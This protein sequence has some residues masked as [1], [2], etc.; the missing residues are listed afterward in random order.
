MASDHDT[1]LVSDENLLSDPERLAALHQTEL[2]DSLPEEAFDRIVR[3][4]RA[5]VGVP[6]SLVSLVDGSRQY[7][8]AQEGLSGDAC[9][10]RGTPLSHSFCQYVVMRDAPLVVRDARDDPVLRDNLAVPD[11]NVIAYLGVPIRAPGGQPIGSFCV[12]DGNPRDWSDA[13]VAAVSDLAATVESEISLRLAVAKRQLLNRELNHRVGNLF[14]VIG[15]MVSMTSRHAETPREMSEVLRGRIAALA[16]AHDLIRP[17]VM[18]TSSSVVPSA[19]STTLSSLIEPHVLRRDDQLHLEGPMLKLGP[20]ATTDLSLVVHELATNAAKYG[21]LSQAG[22]MLRITWQVEGGAVSLRWEEAGGPELANPP[23]AA[24]FGSQLIRVSMSSLGGR[25]ESDW[26]PE[27]VVH[28]LFIAAE[29][30]EAEID[31]V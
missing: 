13:D 20:K 12:I 17:D 18:D 19:L 25:I 5:I 8:K 10:A 26:R 30:F 24:G 3:L 21:A 4:A 15:G 28:T 7:F 6:V 29:L 23:T 31:E 14:A 16:K 11:L 2:L 9:T 22:G 1:R 27:G